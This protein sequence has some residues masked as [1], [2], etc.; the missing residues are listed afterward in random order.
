MIRRRTFAAAA[1]SLVAL[2]A[3]AGPAGA[4]DTTIELSLTG[5]ALTVS[6]PVSVSGSGAI[7]IGSTVDIPVTGVVIDDDRGT[8]L[9]WAATA[10]SAGLTTDDGQAGEGEVITPAQMTWTTDTVSA[11]EGQIALS[12]PTPQ[13]LVSAA[14][15]TGLPLTSAGQFTID[16]TVT[17]AVPFNAKAGDYTGTLVTTVL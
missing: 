1:T 5:G 11:D 13:T 4:A 6:A 10:S 16:G 3:L 8:L 15:A 7:D 14:V 17:V 9:G 2:A 12:L